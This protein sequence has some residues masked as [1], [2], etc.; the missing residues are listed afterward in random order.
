MK[1]LINWIVSL[2]SKRKSL[3]FNFVKEFPK[4]INNNN[5]YIECNLGHNEYWYA[6][7]KC[8]CGCGDVLTLNLMGEDPPYWTLI[9]GNRYSFTPSIRR[10]LKC[11]SHFWIVNS[12]IK[13][14]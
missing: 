2:I 13:W 14:C 8:P 3:Q 10:K 4:V 12:Q 1:R 5:V 11:K 6:K 9:E 7:F